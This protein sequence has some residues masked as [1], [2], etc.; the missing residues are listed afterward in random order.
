[1]FNS[2]LVISSEENSSCANHCNHCEHSTLSTANTNAR[3]T[4][5]WRR[6]ETVRDHV[7]ALEIDRDLPETTRDLKRR[8]RWRRRDHLETNDLCT[9]LLTL[10]THGAIPPQHQILEKLMILLGR[11][12]YF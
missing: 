7:S 8:R 6:L 12:A 5:M 2:A 9:S 3:S 1:M 11:A 10:P 4:R